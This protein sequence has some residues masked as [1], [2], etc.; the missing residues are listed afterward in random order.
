MFLSWYDDLCATPPFHVSWKVPLS[1]SEGSCSFPGSQWPRLTWGLPP[2]FA[3]ESNGSITSTFSDTDRFI[4]PGNS[5]LSE[6]LFRT[7]LFIGEFVL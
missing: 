4:P 1:F 5:P 7:P 3:Y 2:P 6:E